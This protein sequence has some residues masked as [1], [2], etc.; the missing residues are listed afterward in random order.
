M[1]GGG[2]ERWPAF[3]GRILFVS[4][5]FHRVEPRRLDGGINAKP[6]ADR[7]RHNKSQQDGAGGDNG[8]PP[9]RPRDH[10]RHPKTKQNSDDAAYKGNQDGLNDELPD[11]IRPAGPDGP[12]QSDL[13]FFRMVF[14]DDFAQFAR[15]IILISV[16]A[17]ITTSIGYL[18]TDRLFRAEY[19][20]LLL[21]AAVGMGLMAASA[22]LIM[23]FLGIEVLS[24]A[25]YALAGLEETR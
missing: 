10:P 11:D 8:G 6:K 16:G 4:Q 21:F 17:I 12:P 7:N 2:L 22:D 14:Q 13:A 9:G 20:A 23:T 15:L 5:R 3:R 18:E 19:F 24:I 1:S 25:T